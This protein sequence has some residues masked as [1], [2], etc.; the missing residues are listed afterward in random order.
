MFKDY[1]HLR[2]RKDMA[3]GEIRKMSRTVGRTAEDLMKELESDWPVAA[4]YAWATALFLGIAVGFG[5]G[6]WVF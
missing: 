5:I 6:W 1:T 4:H 2:H 3:L